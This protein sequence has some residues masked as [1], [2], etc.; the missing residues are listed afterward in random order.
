MGDV[1]RYGLVLLVVAL[2][3]LVA[4]LSSR[5]SAWLRVPAP[6]I[7]LI[8]AAIASNLVP[9]LGHVPNHTVQRLVTV[10]LVV[11]LF[12]GG[13]HIG[14]RRFRSA[15]GAIVWLGIAGTA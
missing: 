8:G 6:A 9:V 10:A 3:F 11:I 5:V 12:D 13:M 15:A 2:A 14:W 4:I 7:F 1:T